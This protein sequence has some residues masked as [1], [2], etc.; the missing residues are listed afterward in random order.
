M[1]LITTHYV[2][3]QQLDEFTNVTGYYIQR[4]GGDCRPSSRQ[5]EP[6]NFNLYLHQVCCV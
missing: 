4:V 5:S 1:I 3:Q 2:L 6:L